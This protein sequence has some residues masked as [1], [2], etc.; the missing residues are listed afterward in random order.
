MGGLSADLAGNWIDLACLIG[1]VVFFCV[2]Q[3]EAQKTADIGNIK[4]ETLY[5]ARLEKSQ[6]EISD[7]DR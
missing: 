4:A 2:F 5:T 6:S 1:G 3:Y 7:A